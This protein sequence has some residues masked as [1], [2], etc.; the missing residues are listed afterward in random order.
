[1]AKVIETKIKDNFF[2]LFI[3]K[4]TKHN[5]NTDQSNKE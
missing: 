1:M 2:N 4:I 5:I 3:T